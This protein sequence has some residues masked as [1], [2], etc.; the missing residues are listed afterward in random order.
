MKFRRKDLTG[1]KFGKLLVI[2]FERYYANNREAMY[3]CACSCGK[4]KTVRSS[5]LA[6]GTTISCGC[7]LNRRRSSNPE[8]LTP[9]YIW[10]QTYSDCKFETFLSLSQQNCFYC[11]SLPSNKCN[12]YSARKNNKTISQEWFDKC[13]FIYNGLDRI[14]S[15]K[16][17]N[18]DNIVPCC[19][20]CNQAKNDMTVE[21][22][23][24][25]IKLIYKHFIE[26]KC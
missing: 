2:K 4:E 19:I 16:P 14:D 22:F 25:W 23:K 21:E 5:C 3:L 24:T 1:Q 17:H 6:N 10:R 13:W 18:D 15:T 20:L 7:F 12:L 8:L 11:G 26:N 9:K